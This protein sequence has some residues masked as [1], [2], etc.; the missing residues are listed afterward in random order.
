MD[1]KKP[2]LLAPAGGMEH[3]EAAAE[4]GADAIYFG[5]KGF[6][7]REYADNFEPSEMT[8]AIRYAHRKGVKAYMTLNTLV[9]Q[10]ELESALKQGAEG[11]EAGVDAFIIQDLGLAALLR[12][13]LPEI[14]LHLSTQGT[15]YDRAGVKMARELGFKRAVLARELSLEQIRDCAAE[16]GIETEIFVHGA[17]CM[18][19]SG[20]CAMSQ[21]IGGRSGNRG[22]CAQPCRRWYELE[23]EGGEPLGEAG[24][25]L[26]PRDLSYLPDLNAL[27]RAGV[28]SL[29]IE[30]RLK[31]PEYAA[32]TVKT[33]RKYLDRIAGGGEKAPEAR[34]MERLEQVFSRGKFTRGYLYGKP[35]GALLS[36]DS[37]KH[38]GL[39]L[40]EVRKVRPSAMGKEKSLLELEL[41]RD[42]RVGDGIEITAPGFP[43]GVVSYIKG[44]KQP[45]RAAKA[46]ERVWIGDIPG[47]IR[48]GDP[49]YKVTD[50]QLLEEIRRTYEGRMKQAEE[51]GKAEVKGVFIAAEGKPVQFAVSDGRGHRAAARG[52]VILERA[53]KA[54]TDEAAVLT[55]LKKTGNTPFVLAECRMEMEAGLM[56]PMSEVKKVRREALEKLQAL[57]EKN[58]D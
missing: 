24:Y 27:V 22:Q 57:Q 33:F 14:P 3:F 16:P 49:V 51:P 17:L 47:T 38:R 54:P 23:T 31:T 9:K 19:L 32:L 21:L 55:Q 5:G 29:K 45:V 13:E 6:N 10:E 11:A 44:R 18:C 20:Q 41:A 2:E 39:F 56:I 40:G 37:P 30:G 35:S 15:V 12:K 52:T 25:L 1:R 26:S 7:A 48:P 28:D 8:R 36:G 4:N 34:D 46:R 43:G 58:D 50:R 53:E 42:L